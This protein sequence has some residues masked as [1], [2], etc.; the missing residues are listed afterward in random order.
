MYIMG[1]YI[2]REQK[3]WQ[4]IM[5]PSSSQKRGRPMSTLEVLTLLLAIFAALSYINN[6]HNKK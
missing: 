6:K 5:L 3:G 2:K 1:L 4:T